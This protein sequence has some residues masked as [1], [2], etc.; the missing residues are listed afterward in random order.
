MNAGP[1]TSAVVHVV[2]DDDGFRTAMA[3]LLKAAGY[4]VRSYASAGAFLLDR[5]VRRSGC[6]LLDVK[7]PGPSGLELQ[8]ALARQD[9]S[10]PIIFLT[11]HGDIATTV[12]AMKAGAVDFLTKPI[13][14]ETLLPAIQAAMARDVET[15]A[16]RNRRKD[17]SSRLA[18]LTAREREVLAHVIVGKPNKWIASELGTAERTVKAHRAQIMRKMGVLSVAE[19]VH[20]MDVMQLA[21]A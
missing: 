5:E 19:L 10:L 15:R 11:G 1:S 3:R 18:T 4:E 2:D 6:L 21:S 20:L 12:R 16:A 7:L 13:R 14:R 8:D 9:E 17:M